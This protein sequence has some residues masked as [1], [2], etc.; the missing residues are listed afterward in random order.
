[1][2]ELHTRVP[3]P[4]PTVRPVALPEPVLRERAPGP[5]IAAPS[6]QLV[7]STARTSPEHTA[8]VLPSCSAP[9]H[10]QGEGR[11]RAAQGDVSCSPSSASPEKPIMSSPDAPDAHCRTRARRRSGCPTP[12]SARRDPELPSGHAK[13]GQA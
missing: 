11:A 5:Q 6:E 9:Q 4:L 8:S 7:R 3:I 12:P 13:A 2:T 1:M 10:R